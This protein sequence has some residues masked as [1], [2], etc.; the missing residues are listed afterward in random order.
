MSLLKV[1]RQ[2]GDVQAEEAVLLRAIK[3]CGASAS[4]MVGDCMDNKS[5]ATAG[6][7]WGA[8][9]EVYLKFGLLND[10]EAA[11]R[12]SIK[13]LDALPITASQVCEKLRLAQIVRQTGKPEVCASCCDCNVHAPR[14]IRVQSGA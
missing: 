7:L 1:V 12:T 13:M 14:S 3:E 11:A 10:S 5:R 2:L 6:N 9:S 4:D 8:L